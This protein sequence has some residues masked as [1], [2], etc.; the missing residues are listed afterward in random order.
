MSIKIN[1]SCDACGFYKDFRIGTAEI[2]PSLDSVVT[3]FHPKRRPAVIKLIN[4]HTIHRSDFEYRVYYCKKCGQ[5]RNSFWTRIIYDDGE[6]YQTNCLC[7]KCD[8]PMTKMSDYS[9][10]EGKQCPCCEEETLR[11]RENIPLGKMVKYK[12]QQPWN[13][14]AQLS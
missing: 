2:P 10:I 6:L 13:Q 3:Q 4:D 5:L 9:Q 14:W 7:W 1:I 12:N 11:V 8:K